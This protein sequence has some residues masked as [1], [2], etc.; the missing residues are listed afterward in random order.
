[1]PNLHIFVV[2]DNPSLIDV[3]KN[4]LHRSGHTVTSFESPLKVLEALKDT[5]ISRQQVDLL[6]TDLEMPVLNGIGLVNQVRINKINV[7][8]LIMSGNFADYMRDIPK[9]VFTMEKPFTH[10]VLSKK[11][12][13]ATRTS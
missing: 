9:D 3:I 12:T 1:M 11:V 8:I 5:V 13:E 2:D 7:P 10:E 4:L 6:I